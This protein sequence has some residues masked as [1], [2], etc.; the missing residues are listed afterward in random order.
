MISSPASAMANGAFKNPVSAPAVTSTDR[1]TREMPFSR[2]SFP[3]SAPQ[4]RKPF[5]RIIAALLRP[6]AEC[7]HPLQH[8]LRRHLRGHVLPRR[9]E[10]GCARIFAAMTGTIGACTA[11]PRPLTGFR[12]GTAV[13][14]KKPSHFSA[15]RHIYAHAVSH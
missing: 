9:N 1:P 2:S 11:G 8:P 3:A 4:T 7:L 5:H 12:H 14:P 10:P 6:L 15:P 13:E